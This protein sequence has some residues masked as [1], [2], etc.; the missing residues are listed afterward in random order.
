M[1]VMQLREPFRPHRIRTDVSVRGRM[2]ICVTS[3]VR[4]EDDAGNLTRG[5]FVRGTVGGGN[6]HGPRA[7]LSSQSP[8]AVHINDPADG[9]HPAG[10]AAVP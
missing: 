6:L 10:D 4:P 9:C 1:G 7:Q 2:E 3:R 5:Q 8:S